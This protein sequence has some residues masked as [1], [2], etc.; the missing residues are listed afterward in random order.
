MHYMK[1]KYIIQVK[2]ASNKTVYTVYSN[3][4]YINT[5]RRKLEIHLPKSSTLVVSRRGVTGDFS[6][7]SNYICD[8][9]GKILLQYTPLKT[10]QNQ[11]Y[12]EYKL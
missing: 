10:V 12:R 6:L 11:T 3:V 2:K 4:K 7:I 5:H 9:D 8:L 1:D